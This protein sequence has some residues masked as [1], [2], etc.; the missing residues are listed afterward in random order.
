[1][2]HGIFTLVTSL[3]LTYSSMVWW[4]RV[5]NVSRMELSEVKR[6]AC[7]V[8]T[9]AMKTTPTAVIEVLL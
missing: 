8:V 3:I 9:G 7:V 2:V 6:L 5:K 1:M 4:P